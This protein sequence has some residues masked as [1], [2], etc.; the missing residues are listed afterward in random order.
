MFP[1]LPTPPDGRTFGRTTPVASFLTCSRCVAF[2]S[3]SEVENSFPSTPLRMG[4]Q[5]SKSRSATSWTA[6]SLWPPAPS[7]S[8]MTSRNGPSEKLVVSV[9]SSRWHWPH[10]NRRGRLVFVSVCG[11]QST[12]IPSAAVTASPAETN[13]RVLTA[14]GRTIASGVGKSVRQPPSVSPEVGS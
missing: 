12:A 1:P 2:A 6:N 9:P 11:G 10:F 14:F 3:P 4:C 13:P 8:P 5:P 7:L